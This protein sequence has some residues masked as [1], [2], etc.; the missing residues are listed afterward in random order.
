MQRFS[1]RSVLN[2]AFGV[3]VGTGRSLNGRLWGGE[4]RARA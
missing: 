3:G 1:A 4:S 2:K